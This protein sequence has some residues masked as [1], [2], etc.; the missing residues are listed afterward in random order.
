MINKQYCYKYPRPMVTTDIAL[1][2][3]RQSIPSVLLVQRKNEPAKNAW[4][5]PGG[6]LEMDEN[7]RDS[8]YRE[9]QE[10]T[11]ISN[12]TIYQM[13]TVGTL[14]RDPRGRVITVI[15]S[16]FYE[17]GAEPHHGSDARDARWFSLKEL[18]D[19]AFD[20]GSILAEICRLWIS[21]RLHQNDNRFLIRDKFAEEF[22]HV[23][24]SCLGH[25]GII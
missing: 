6:F 7:L 15:Y 14:D 23:Q 8:A 21:I 3:I 11:G 20:H 18:P 10:E 5:L 24:L 25:E 19:L 13:F 9:L 1:F 22:A 4:A 2:S 12:V 16:G 17:H